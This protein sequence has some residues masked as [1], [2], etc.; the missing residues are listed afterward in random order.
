MGTGS[1]NCRST[2]APFRWGPC[3]ASDAAKASRELAGRLSPRRARRSFKAQLSAAQHRREIIARPV[4]DL[5]AT[6]LIG[7]PTANSLRDK[8][9]PPLALYERLDFLRDTL[10]L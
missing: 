2:S 5:W 1:C 4:G 3:S 10:R 7:A 6:A 8:H 9:I